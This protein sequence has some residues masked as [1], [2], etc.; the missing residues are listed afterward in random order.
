MK[1]LKDNLST[2]C[3]ILFLIGGA[4]VSVGATGGIAEPTWLVSGAGI[5]T[6]VSG[7]IVGFLTGK[8]PN[9]STKSVEQTT[10]QNSQAAK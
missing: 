3:G 2:I 9:G 8:N 4:I 5:L 6:A 10:T 1:N 7:A